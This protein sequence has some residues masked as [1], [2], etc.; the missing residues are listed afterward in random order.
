MLWELVVDV[1]LFNMHNR[2]CLVQHKIDTPCGS[3][4]GEDGVSSEWW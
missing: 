2:H 4:P 1:L 3:D